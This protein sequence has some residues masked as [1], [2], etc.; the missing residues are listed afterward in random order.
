MSTFTEKISHCRAALNIVQQRLDGRQVEIEYRNVVKWDSLIDHTMEASQRPENGPRNRYCNVLPYDHNRVTLEQAS[1]SNNAGYVNASHVVFNETG[2]GGL[3]RH[4]IATQGPL[5]GTV[6]DFWSLV[7]PRSP[8]VR[9]GI[10][11]DM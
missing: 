10:C 4:Y 8:G 5:N 2:P 3:C 7:R 11:D 6:E 9:L 1:S